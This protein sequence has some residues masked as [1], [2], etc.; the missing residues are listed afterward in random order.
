MEDLKESP[1]SHADVGVGITT[2]HRMPDSLLGL[3]EDE[4]R[5]L[6]KKLVRKLDCV[7]LPI[8]GILYIVSAGRC[9]LGGNRRWS[10]D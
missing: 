9:S 10:M 3:S 8:I 4:V 5:V 7:I 6:N 2:N 1:S